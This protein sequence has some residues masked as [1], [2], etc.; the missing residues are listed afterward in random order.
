MEG[1]D[2][3]PGQD[4]QFPLNPGDP[5]FFMSY[6]RSVD[7]GQPATDAAPDQL[8]KVLFNDLSADVGE[9]TA[10]AVGAFPGFLDQRINPGKEWEPELLHA[11]G[12]C[13]VFVPL[14]SE[15]LLGS[16]WCQREWDAFAR[17]EV[18]ARP[19]NPAV[20]RR[21][22]ILPVLWAPLKPRST[23]RTVSAVQRFTPDKLGADAI[24]QY[25]AEGL[26]GLL[27]M[28]NVTA[29]RS[30]VWFLARQVVNLHWAYYVRP[31]VFALNE[32]NN[33]FAEVAP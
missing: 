31:K 22:A 4:E 5:L 23:P 9:L 7:S 13:Q 3:E 8:V 11:L 2:D 15:G 21:T 20:G 33:A 26:Y 14:L 24:A 19:G 27:K 28:R 12:T 32:L 1:G 29:Y 18:V 10:R 25:E 17:R 30:T 6:A 16:W